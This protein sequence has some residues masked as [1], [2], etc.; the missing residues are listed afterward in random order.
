VPNGE[1]IA[2]RARTAASPD[3][4]IEMNEKQIDSE[5]LAALLEER[6]K[7]NEKRLKATRDF[8]EKDRQ[9][10]GRISEFEL[11]VGEVARCGR[12]KI[13]RTRRAGGDR[14]FTVAPSEPL[15]IRLAVD[16]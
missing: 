14:A 5:D 15:Q 7:L 11:A 6:L 8:E 16:D 1:S 10:K 2:E 13:K 9:A 4:Q 12:F 3:D